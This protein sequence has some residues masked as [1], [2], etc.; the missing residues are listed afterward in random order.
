MALNYAKCVVSSVLN[1]LMVIKLWLALSN[2]G[3]DHYHLFNYKSQHYA[4]QCFESCK[5]TF[6]LSTWCMLWTFSFYL[7]FK[8]KKI[9]DGIIHLTECMYIDKPITTFMNYIFL[10]RTKVF[11]FSIF[12]SSF[13]HYISIL[14]LITRFWVLIMVFFVSY[15]F[16][17]RINGSLPCPLLRNVIHGER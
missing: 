15:F 3:G 6:K 11:S 1:Y 10:V 7:M 13:Y 17:G 14:L 12:I 2:F 16:L 4:I 8:R 9:L 5:K